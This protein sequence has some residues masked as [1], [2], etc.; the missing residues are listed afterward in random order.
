MKQQHWVRS[1]LLVLGTG[2]AAVVAAPPYFHHQRA[3]TCHCIDA[4][5]YRS[6]GS[7][8]AS[9][10]VILIAR[11]LPPRTVAL[12]PVRD[13]PAAVAV[14][15]FDAVPITSLRAGP[16]TLGSV[17]AAVYANGEIFCTGIARHDGGP[18]RA[19]HGGNVAVRVRLLMGTAESPHPPETARVLLE[20]DRHYWV[21]RERSQTVAPL[22][23]SA[24]RG[25]G[26]PL[27]SPRAQAD[28]I[29]RHFDEITHIEITLDYFQD[30]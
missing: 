20:A 22:A 9:D 4:R 29:A 27:L 5:H 7:V 26:Q 23:T 13:R 15:Q 6:G 3:I 30:R 2:Q 10:R 28:L 25:V 14:K 8:A 1:A 12:Y 11:P 16:V 19:L 21:S 17:S 18:Q 24:K